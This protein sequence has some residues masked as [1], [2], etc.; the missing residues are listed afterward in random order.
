MNDNGIENLTQVLSDYLEDAHGQSQM[1]VG[2]AAVEELS[3]L[4]NGAISWADFLSDDGDE[5]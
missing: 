4:T 1:D 5:S 2:R 3:R